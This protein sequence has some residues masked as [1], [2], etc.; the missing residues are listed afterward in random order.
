MEEI[1][2]IIKEIEAVK[3]ANEGLE[4]NNIKK[5]EKYENSVEGELLQELDETK[6]FAKRI[7]LIQKIKNIREEKMQELNVKL[8]EKVDKIKENI[9]IKEKT[10]EDN[11]KALYVMKANR[12][13]LKNSDNTIRPEMKDAYNS[14]TEDMKEKM[15]EN[16]E[17]HLEL[18]E[19]RQDIEFIENKKFSELIQKYSEENV[20]EEQIPE[21]PNEAEQEPAIEN[22][23]EQV[24]EPVIEKEEEPI[25]SNEDLER[26]MS[27]LENSIEEDKANT[28]LANQPTNFL[29]KFGNKTKEIWNKV[30]SFFKTTYQKIKGVIQKNVNTKKEPVVQN[31]QEEP[32]TSN[33]W[34]LT[35]EEK[36]MIEQFRTTIRQN[37]QDRPD[38]EN[39]QEK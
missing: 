30:K 26:F 14:I 16:R 22:K 4:N 24:A 32:K 29:V 28:Q 1:I 31:T 6:D 38:K 25:I 23:E 27:S 33:S 21:V 20:H 35:P 10:I 37:R 36:K 15:K 39:E 9:Q 18:E 5:T 2:E 17:L 34:E 8:S 11:K 19:N 12:D 13:M 7:E 3:K